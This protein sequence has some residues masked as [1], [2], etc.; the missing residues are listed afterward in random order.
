MTTKVDMNTRLLW[1]KKMQNYIV[2][3]WWWCN[4]PRI[5]FSVKDFCK[6]IRNLYSVGWHLW[7]PIHPQWCSIHWSRK[8]S[9]EYFQHH[10]R[11]G[12]GGSSICIGNSMIFN[13]H[14]YV[15]QRVWITSAIWGNEKSC[16]YLLI[17]CGDNFES[18][19]LSNTA[20]QSTEEQW[21]GIT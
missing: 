18:N 16:Y 17:I 21:F 3:K 6:I 5:A 12:R 14:E 10:A 20:P 13:T 7:L 2:A 8:K 4:A 11:A 9:T 1:T 15:F 19:F